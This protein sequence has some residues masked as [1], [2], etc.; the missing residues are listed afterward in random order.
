MS[1]N[2]RFIT[3]FFPAFRLRATP[4]FY[5]NPLEADG[6]VKFNKG[7]C[8]RSPWFDCSC[9]PVNVVRVLPS[10]PGYIYA[11]KDEDV[12]VNLYIGNEAELE[13]NG[14]KISDRTENELPLGREY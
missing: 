12:F 9:C 1:L 4:F 14:E 8:G 3:D 7:V 6:I 5:P 11:V 10:L 13:V 2:E